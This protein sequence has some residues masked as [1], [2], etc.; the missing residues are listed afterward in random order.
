M[1]FSVC[2]NH[3]Q[4]MKC[5]EISRITLEFEI[6]EHIREIAFMNYKLVFAD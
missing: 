1:L 2:W 6:V 4:Y 3:R 5:S